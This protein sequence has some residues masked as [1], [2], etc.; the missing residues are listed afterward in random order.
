EV[1][2]AAGRCDLLKILSLRIPKHTGWDQDHQVRVAC[3]DIDV[4]VSIVVQIAII[5][6]HAEKNTVQMHRVAH[7]R[8]SAISI[9][10]VEMG[11]VPLDGQS[12]DIVHG[13]HRIANVVVDQEYVRPAVIIVIE[14]HRSE[15]MRRYSDARCVG[16]IRESTVPV[17]V[18]EPLLTKRRDKD[19]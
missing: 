5:I 13:F 11:V 16:N 14:K 2:E 7:I 1:A 18:V 8:K 15:T 17:V 19:I 12:L 4:R 6:A 9:I 10:M 3:T